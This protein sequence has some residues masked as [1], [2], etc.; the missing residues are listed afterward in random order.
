MSASAKLACQR[1]PVLAI[2]MAAAELLL[3]RGST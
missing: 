1:V 3:L 2:L